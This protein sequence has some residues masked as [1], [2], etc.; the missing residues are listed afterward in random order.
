MKVCPTAAAIQSHVAPIVLQ[1]AEFVALE[2]RKCVQNGRGDVGAFEREVQGRL[3]SMGAVLVGELLKSLD[4][5]CPVVTEEGV[6]YKCVTS[7]PKT[8]LTL[9]GPVEVEHHR[10]RPSGRNS[11]SVSLIEERAGIVNGYFTPEAARM[12]LLLL[13][14]STVRDASR[15]CGEIGMAVSATSLQRLL[16]EISSKWEEDRECNE[17]QL[18][19]E[20]EFLS[21]AAVK[22]SAV[23]NPAVVCLSMDGV[24]APMRAD[25]AAKLESKAS[26]SKASWSKS[27]GPKSSGPKSSGCY[28]ELGCGTVTLYDG[29]G[30]RLKS[31]YHGRMPE[32]R[33]ATLTSQLQGEMLHIQKEQPGLRRVYLCDGAEVN[34]R[35]AELVEAE[36]KKK[37]ARLGQTSPESICIVDFYHACEHLK[38]A[39]D[40]IHGEGT[41]AGRNFYTER[42]MWLYRFNGG[43]QQL[44]RSL[45]YYLGRAKAERK[46]K[47]QAE[48]TYF[49]NQAARMDY[50]EYRNKNLPIGSGVVEAACKTLVT[51]RMKR[52]GMLWSQEGGQAVLNVRAWTGSGRFDAAVR[53]M[54]QPRAFYPI[55][56]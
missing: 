16:I 12:A 47:I 44:C 17:E 37:E 21:K 19:C 34:W 1:L 10:Y 7:G 46:K 13:A 9:F 36:M 4:L 15:I 52:S 22:N 55:A 11:P 40:A 45:H 43:V 27:S 18:Q 3:D 49:E 56:H 39:A 24:M 35:N 25:A 53:L 41:D 14:D 29:A 20:S 50:I 51:S 2:V 8:F 5:E 54:T 30:E 26:G 32:P 23:K 33:K 31:L 42:K 6:L 48:L 28:R 38:R